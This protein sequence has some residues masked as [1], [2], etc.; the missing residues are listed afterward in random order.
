MR[1]SGCL[2]TRDL[3]VSLAILFSFIMPATA[4]DLGQSATAH[5]ELL[6]RQIPLPAGD[7]TVVGRGTNALASGNPGAYGTIENAILAR[8]SDGRIDALVE[9]NVNRL[10]V[11]G[12]WGVAADCTRDG[13]LAMLTVRSRSEEHTSELQS[14]MRISYAVFCLKKK[15]ST[16]KL[17]VHTK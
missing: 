11:T 10:P 3:I 17:I 4:A 13:G 15:K 1:L 2:T 8:R 5:V 14:L 6:D 12:G 16:T 9:I 7:W